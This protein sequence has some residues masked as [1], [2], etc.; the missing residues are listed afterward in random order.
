MP[1]R[2]KGTNLGRRTKKKKKCR[3][4]KYKSIEE[5]N[6]SNKTWHFR[7]SQS[8]EARDERNR[9]RRLEQRQARRYVVNTRRAIDQQRQQAHRA[10][11]SDS[12]LLLAFQYEPDVEYYV[13]YKVDI[14]TM[15]KECPHCHALKFKNEPAGLCCASVKVQLPEIETPPEPL[16]AYLSVRI[17]IL[18]CS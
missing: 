11:T 12:F 17:Q 8:Q 3:R 7:E 15:D 9:Q 16:H 4:A 14:G 1:A 13:H 10:F 6:K 5:T 18:A 2:R